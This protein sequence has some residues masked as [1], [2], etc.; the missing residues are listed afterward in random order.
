MDYSPHSDYS[1]NSNLRSHSNLFQKN[2]EN[3]K[4]HNQQLR[5]PKNHNI[6][7]IFFF[8]FGVGER[9]GGRAGEKAHTHTRVRTRIRI[10]E[11]ASVCVGLKFNSCQLYVLPRFCMCPHLRPCMLLLDFLEYMFSYKE[12]IHLVQLNL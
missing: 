12:G 11:H 2:Q 5:T 7:H 4:H 10:H 3:R 6:T 8:I 9:A 1:N